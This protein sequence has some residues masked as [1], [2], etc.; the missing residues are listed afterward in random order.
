M[1]MRAYTSN[2]RGRECR[3]CEFRGEHRPCGSDILVRQRISTDLRC[4][5]ITDKKQN[6]KYK[7]KSLGQECPSHTRRC[8]PNVSPSR[9][10]TNIAA[11]F[12]TIR[13]PIEQYS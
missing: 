3:Y 10:C 4:L 5:F 13:K 1:K 6:L 12:L 11:C 2:C 8:T 7:P 9:G